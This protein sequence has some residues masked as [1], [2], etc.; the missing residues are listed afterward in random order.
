MSIT[1]G[2]MQ[3]VNYTV[4]G[5]SLSVLE[6]GQKENPIALF[7]HGIPANVLVWQKV[8]ESMSQRGYCVYAIELPGFGDTDV[9]DD[10]YYGILGSAKLAMAWVEQLGLNNIWLISHDIG[11]GVAQIMLTMDES[12][13][14]KAVFSNSITAD[15]WPVPAMIELINA[16]NAGQYVPAAEAGNIQ[17]EL[18]SFIKSTFVHQ[19]VITDELMTEIFLDGKVSTPAGR[20]K[21]SN[22]L[23]RL[24]NR[25]TIAIMPDLARVSLPVHLIWAMKDPHQ[26]WDGSGQILEKT[27][28]NIHVSRIEDSGHF[29]Q[30]DAADEYLNFLISHE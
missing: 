27:F 21:F 9:I 7:I 14:S 13:F 5:N 1:H 24:D 29:L 17:Q 28:R 19:D 25:E 10:S 18:G 30:L 26:P 2:S 6:V 16:A 15:S 23:T 4:Q 11:G 3:R 12:R 20:E 8:L 22:L